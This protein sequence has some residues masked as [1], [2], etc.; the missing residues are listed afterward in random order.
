M[1][2][3]TAPA[4]LI[5]LIGV[6]LGAANIVL[7]YH[8]VSSWGIACYAIVTGVLQ[9]CKNPVGTVMLGVG[10]IALLG[11]RVSDLL[12]GRVVWSVSFYDGIKAVVGLVWYGSMVAT[13]LSQISYFRNRIS[14]GD[15]NAEHAAP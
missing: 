15:S 6:A 9:V 8:N 3:F 10:L 13:V 7:D 12:M 2:D 4:C 1:L 14:A 5:I 11:Y